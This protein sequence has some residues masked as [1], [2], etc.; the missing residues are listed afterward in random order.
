MDGNVSF[1]ARQQQAKRQFISNHEFLFGVKAHA[2]LTDICNG[3]W[4]PSMAVV[5]RNYGR[6]QGL[7]STSAVVKQH[8][9]ISDFQRLQ[10][11]FIRYRL[12][13]DDVDTGHRTI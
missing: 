7:P 8:S 4:H 12:F 13:K 6:H 10:S 5:R 2:A 11:G 3:Q 9:G 1:L